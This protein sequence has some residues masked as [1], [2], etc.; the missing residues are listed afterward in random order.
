VV[1]GYGGAFPLWAG[2]GVPEHIKNNVNK[3][4]SLWVFE[5]AE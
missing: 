4:A 2:K 1:S 5:L 3:G